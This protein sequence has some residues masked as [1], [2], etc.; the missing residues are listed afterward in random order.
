MLHLPLDVKAVWKLL[1]PALQI[2]AERMAKL[3]RLPLPEVDRL[4]LKAAS[5]LFFDA[6]VVVARILAPLSPAKSQRIELGKSFLTR[7][8]NYI[9]RLKP[10][11]FSLVSWKLFPRCPLMCLDLG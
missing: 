8:V 3:P 2:R 1:D 9:L 6:L 5:V 11:S 7:E 4:W 10:S